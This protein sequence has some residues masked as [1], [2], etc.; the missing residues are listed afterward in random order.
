[1]P[2][3]EGGGRVTKGKFGV[4]NARAWSMEENCAN[5]KCFDMPSYINKLSVAEN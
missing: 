2:C 5:P 1:M 3:E 4:T